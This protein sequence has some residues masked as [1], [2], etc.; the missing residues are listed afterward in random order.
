VRPTH[1]Q[2]AA[3]QATAAELFHRANQARDA[4]QVTD[5][6]RDYSQL[7]ERFPESSEAQ[8][9]RI[10][11]GKLLSARG[12]RLEADREFQDYLSGGRGPLDEE[13]LLGRAR[14]LQALARRDDERATWQRLLRDHPN[15]V[16]AEQA[17]RR[18]VQLEVRESP[19]G[20]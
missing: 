20:P 18:L 7:V 12:A 15:S 16:Y 4:D 14:V 9:A 6:Q 3:L 2:H 5:A 19:R 1:S 8:L 10:S 17:R 11:L 13:A